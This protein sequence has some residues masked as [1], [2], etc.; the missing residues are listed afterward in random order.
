MHGLFQ[1]EKD[2][3]RIFRSDIDGKNSYCFQ[4]KYA[5]LG[6]KVATVFKTCPRLKK[7]LKPGFH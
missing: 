3:N 4:R 5:L 1:E 2:A 6:T 7:T